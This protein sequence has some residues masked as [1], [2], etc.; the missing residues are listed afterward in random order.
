M[1]LGGVLGIQFSTNRTAEISNLTNS[2]DITLDAT[3]STKNSRIGGVIG[4]AYTDALSKC[5]NSG[6][7]TYN[8][9]AFTYLYCGGILGYAS[10]SCIINDVHNKG[11]ITI[12]GEVKQLA[13]LVLGGV[14]GYQQDGD[15]IGS[16][17]NAI[18]EP[19]RDF[20]EQSHS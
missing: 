19:C 4:W 20:Q 6:N 9:G 8:S 13:D 16:L 11:A 18:N 12:K 15:A 3:F 1:S 5:V 2:G 10:T 14:V 17:D 7:F